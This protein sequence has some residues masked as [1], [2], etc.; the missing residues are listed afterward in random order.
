MQMHPAVLGNDPRHCRFADTGRPIEYHIGNVP[1]VDGTA[2][3][4]VFSQK[5]LLTADFIQATGTQTLC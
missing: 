1:A 2:E 5:M 4:L 3:H